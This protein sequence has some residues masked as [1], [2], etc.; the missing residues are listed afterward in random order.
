MP[1]LRNSKTA[2][3]I[4]MLAERGFALSVHDPLADPAE[5]LA[6]YGLRL[7]ERLPAQ[8]TF[9]AVLAGVPHRAYETLDGAALAGL[10]RAGGLVADLKGLWR[11]LELPE[12]LQRWTL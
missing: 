6:R 11:H 4:L 10:L 3:L 5:A 12:G 1:D 9:D 8:G 2:E 7:L